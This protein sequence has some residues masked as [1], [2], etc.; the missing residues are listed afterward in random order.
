MA[1]PKKKA[2]TKK[3]S[4]KKAVAKK[5]A[6]KKKVKAKKKDLTMKLP[7]DLKV[8]EVYNMETT[9][10]LPPLSELNWAKLLLDVPD[11]WTRTKGAGITVAVLD[12]GID[13]SH[14]AFKGRIVGTKDFTGHGVDDLNGHGTHCAGIIA[15]RPTPK[16]TF[17]GVAP[18][19]KLL[20]GKVLGNDGSGSYDSISR[21]IDW[22]VSKKADIISMSLG[23]P[24]STNQL[25]MSVQNALHKGHGMIVAA[26]NAGGLD[27]N[28]IGTP[29]IYG[30]VITVAAHDRNGNPSGFSSRGGELD[31]MAPG[32]DIWST[33]TGN[34]YA[35]LSGTSMATPF[36][37]G[38]AALC[39][40]K[41]KSAATN[42]TPIEN[43]FDLREHLMWM[44]SHPGWHDNATG[45]G[46]L[47]PF[48]DV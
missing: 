48:K 14:P 40:S 38:I 16:V 3:K 29:G 5:S 7:G 39:M 11:V 2:G 10:A 32:Q 30:G 43:N 25:Y 35:K 1:K 46:P 33:Y 9:A 4:R 21:G 23:G 15:A 19:A 28:N 31:F 44:A 45:Y 12:T 41:H 42:H 26:G 17:L 6:S 18:D 47:L 37:A 22:A 36:V 34:S 27:T 13:L 8:H 20:I 24:G